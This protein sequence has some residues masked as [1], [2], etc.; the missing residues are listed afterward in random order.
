MHPDLSPHLHTDECNKYT[1]EFKNCNVEVR[2]FLH[3]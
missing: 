2:N 3:E 1:M